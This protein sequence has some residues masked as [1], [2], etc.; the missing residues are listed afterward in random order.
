M[1]AI[2]GS[3]GFEQLDEGEVLETLP[4]ETPFGLCSN[5]LQRVRLYGREFLF[6]PRTGAGENVLPSHIN[7]RANIYALKKY[8]ATAI[9]ALSSV[10]SLKRELKPGD[11]VVPYQYID[12]TKLPRNSTFCDDDM[13]GYVSLA[14]PVSER[15][16]ERMRSKAE[17]FDFACHFNQ[18]YICIEGPQFPTMMDARCFQHMGGGVIGMTAFPE[19]ALAREAGLHYLPCHF[20]VDYL[21]WGEKTP[22][23][24]CVLEIR[25]SNYEKALSVIH[26]VARHLKHYEQNDCSALGLAGALNR[27]EDQLS[28]WQRSWLPTIIRSNSR[29]EQATLASPA[30][31][32]LSAFHR[33]TQPMPKKLAEFLSFVNKYRPAGEEQASLEE[34]RKNAASLSFY[35][36]PGVEL[37]SVRNFT[38]KSEDR[39]VGVRLYHPHEDEARPVLVYVHGGG[40]VS[41]TLDSFDS[42]C[43]NLAWHSGRIVVSVDYHLAPEYPYPAGLNDVYAVC[44]WV[45]DNLHNIRATQ[46]PLVLAGDSSGGCYAALVTSRA[47]ASGDFSVGAQVLIYPT[48]DMTHAYPSME[49]FKT[50]YLLE[51][52]RVRWY[53]ELYVPDNMDKRSGE[54]SPIYASNLADMPETLVITAG[55]DPLKDEALAYAA[56]LETAGVRVHHYHFDDMIHAFLNFGKLVPNAVNTLYERTAAFLRQS[57]GS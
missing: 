43:R 49:N 46:E 18:A 11:M 44:R 52:R 53:N 21:P 55:Y 32:D 34:V 57:A 41:G 30:D 54:I 50:G 27:P 3:S 36:D 4:R 38:V 26:F 24:D 2:I 5:G 31:L 12:R 56:R 8:G 23:V 6:L 28:P 10:R 33:G 37:P 9:L 7:N 22:K 25:H 39:Q 14:R 42:F 45:S 47:R 17:N 35:A 1:W 40:F 48:T 20:V 15:I 51:A 19:Y 13:L 29:H 16:A